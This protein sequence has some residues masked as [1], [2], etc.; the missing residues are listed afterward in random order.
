[1]SEHSTVKLLNTL[2]LCVAKAEILH[3]LPSSF[4]QIHQMQEK[5]VVVKVF[6]NSVD[7]M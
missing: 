7:N 3:K 4:L 2:N 1:M 6:I 5:I